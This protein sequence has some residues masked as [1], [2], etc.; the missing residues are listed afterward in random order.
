MK[1]NMQ[2]CPY[3]PVHVRTGT[4]VIGHD[5]RTMRRQAVLLNCEL[6]WEGS[7]HP[8]ALV[9]GLVG[10]CESINSSLNTEAGS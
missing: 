7:M 4:P 9:T 10:V 3:S 2:G 8:T 1:C 6:D 5:S